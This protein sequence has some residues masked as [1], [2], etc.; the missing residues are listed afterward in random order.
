ML[1]HLSLAICWGE[2]HEKGMPS[3]I[4]TQHL[5]GKREKENKTK[6][7]KKH[8][9]IMN[10]GTIVVLSPTRRTDRVDLSHQWRRMWN[11]REL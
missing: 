2:P 8:I 7:R 5:G 1:H 11:A 4:T 10:N 3:A 9:P 6:K